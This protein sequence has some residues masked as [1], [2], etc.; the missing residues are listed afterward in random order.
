MSLL[1][2]YLPIGRSM[3]AD[4]DDTDTRWECR[5]AGLYG[6]PKT[7]W[8]ASTE[9]THWPGPPL[10]MRGGR[11]S[12]PLRNPPQ[13]LLPSYASSTPNPYTPANPYITAS[14]QAQTT[15]PTPTPGRTVHARGN[16]SPHH[17][18][19]QPNRSSPA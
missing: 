7:L 2:A 10:Y 5:R 4:E 1:A 17:S 16:T 12:L 13:P 15:Q 18:I 9:R 6:Y 3:T 14:V 19:P 11:L 8:D